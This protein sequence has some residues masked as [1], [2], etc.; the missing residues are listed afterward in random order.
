M[1]IHL[2]VYVTGSVCRGQAEW[3]RRTCES[4]WDVF[5]MMNDFVRERGYLGTV[6]IDNGD[7]Y[8][9]GTLADANKYGHEK[10][11]VI[12]GKHVTDTEEL[13]ALAVEVWERAVKQAMPI[14]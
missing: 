7:D 9:T 10:W 2:R 3:F 6:Q 12:K 13:E 8:S 14:G 5:Q 4:S 1:S 11:A